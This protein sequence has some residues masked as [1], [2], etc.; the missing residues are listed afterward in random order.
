ME[1]L[2]IGG[3]TFMVNLGPNGADGMLQGQGIDTKTEGEVQ[4]SQISRQRYLKLNKII[5]LGLQR[6]VPMAMGRDHD[7]RYFWITP[8]MED[9]RHYISQEDSE[10]LNAHI[11]ASIG[12]A[13]AIGHDMLVLKSNNLEFGDLQYA[14]VFVA[15]DGTWRYTDGHRRHPF[16]V[17]QGL[18]ALLW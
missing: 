16:S 2:E 8:L 4:F 18:S 9:F 11:P 5:N 13:I 7:F 14:S 15:H 1:V 17:V 12:N 10:R 3:R 6:M